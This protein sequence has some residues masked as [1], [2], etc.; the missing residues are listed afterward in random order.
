MTEKPYVLTEHDLMPSSD[1]AHEMQEALLQS[2]MDSPMS[3]QYSSAD[4]LDRW[5]AS[6]EG[7]TLYSRGGRSL[8]LTDAARDLVQTLQ[9]LILE[10][11][12]AS[13]GNKPVAA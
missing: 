6:V 7:M 5:T 4:Y 9:E 10:E 13:N 2:I 11:R 8:R 12:I 1:V 3:A